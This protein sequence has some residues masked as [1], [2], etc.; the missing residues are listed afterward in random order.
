MAVPYSE[1]ME[2]D[3]ALLR[4]LHITNKYGVAIVSGTPRDK[5]AVQMLRNQCFATRYCFT[6]AYILRRGTVLPGYFA[7]RVRARRASSPHLLWSLPTQPPGTSRVSRDHWSQAA[8]RL[9]HALGHGS[10][11]IRSASRGQGRRLL[12]DGSTASRRWYDKSAIFYAICYCICYAVFCATCLRYLP[13]S[14]LCCVLRSLPISCY[15]KPG[16][17]E[18]TELRYLPRACYAEPGTDGAYGAMGPDKNIDSAYS[19]V[20]LPAHTDGSYWVDPPGT[21]PYLASCLA[22][23]SLLLALPPASIL[24]SSSFLF[25]FTSSA[26]WLLKATLSVICGQH[27]YAPVTDRE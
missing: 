11:L 4:L 5:V 8:M 6:T 24:F 16:T 23:P 20:A 27:S 21:L 18:L 17:R 15:A 9:G 22:L 7:A 1:M 13:R 2:D 25:K 12:G 10:R 3:R 26:S 14:L 19:T